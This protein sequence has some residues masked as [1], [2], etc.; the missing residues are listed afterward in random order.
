MP[1]ADR[2]DVAVVGA[3]VVGSAIAWE[4][5]RT[6]RRV[7]L[8]DAA[9]GSGATWAAGGMLG[10]AGE[11]RQ[12]EEEALALAQAAATVYPDFLASLPGA[13]GVGYETVPTLLAGVDGADRAGLADLAAVHIA[14]GLGVRRLS[15]R[16][17]RRVEPLIGPAVTSAYLVDS[18]HRVD[19]RALGRVLVAALRSLQASAPLA[20]AAEEIGAASTDGRH[21]RLADGRTVV[22]SEV[23]VATGAHAAELAGLREHLDG[24]IRPVYGDILRAKV[25]A[26][27]RPLLTTTVRASVEGRPVYLIPRQDDTVVIGA[28]EREHGDCDVSMGGVHGLLRDAREVVPALDELTLMETTARARPGTPDN[29]PLVGR[30]APGLSVATGTYRSGVLL[31]PLIARLCAR[32]VDGDVLDDWPQLRPDRFTT[33]PRI[34]AGAPPME[35]EK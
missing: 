28:T 10:V 2:A 14:N 1:G 13:D 31:A 30:I 24:L 34:G 15:L 12:G 6:G 8:I 18:D 23:I 7:R 17:I 3:G 33:A 16:E 19:P 26:S 25:P 29:L 22:A 20:S 4:L 21:L 11:H 27:L 5:A 35:E 32:L 9:P